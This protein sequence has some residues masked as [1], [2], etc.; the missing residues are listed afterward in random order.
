MSEQTLAR[1]RKRFLLCLGMALGALLL[2]GAREVGHELH[3]R[4]ARRQQVSASLREWSHT[5][6][7]ETAGAIGEN[8]GAPG[9]DSD[10]FLIRCCSRPTGACVE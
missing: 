2:S 6:R 1:W 8:C 7:L 3:Q 4:P 5:L 9:L 10:L